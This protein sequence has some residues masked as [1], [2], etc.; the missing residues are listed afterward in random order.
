MNLFIPSKLI[1]IDPDK[2]SIVFI[3]NKVFN[4]SFDHIYGFGKIIIDYFKSLNKYNVV[5][6]GYEKANS[7]NSIENFYTFNT[8]YFLGLS[9]KFHRKVDDSDHTVY[10]QSFINK[11][12][13]EL[14]KD[15]DVEKVIILGDINFILPLTGYDTRTVEDH[16]FKKMQNEYFDYTGESQAI[17]NT[18]DDIN[19]KIV[20]KYDSVCNLLA[21]SMYLKNIFPNLIKFFHMNSKN[22]DKVYNFIIDPAFYTPFFNYNSIPTIN[23]Y[24]ADDKR[25]TRDFTKF[26]IAEL[27]HLV[28]E[29]SIKKENDLFDMFNAGEKNKD[30]FFMGS[31]LQSKGQRKNMW[32]LFLNNL[33]LNSD[34]NSLFVPLVMNGVRLKSS[35]GMNVRRLSKAKEKLPELVDKI[36]NHKLHKGDVT[37]SEITSTIQNYKY[38]LVLRCVSLNDS[39]NFRLI[40]YLS[41]DIIPFLDFLY[42]PEYLQIPKKFQDKLVVNDHIDIM[43]KINYYNINIDDRIKLLQDMKEYYSINSFK[44]K[45]N[46]YFNKEKYK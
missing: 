26:P 11:E 46:K 24:F 43:N 37:P 27:Q 16:S 33:E 22:F 20:K 12:Y 40:K 34:K 10:N 39:L 13:K 7:V 15:L 3:T 9:E 1:N 36:I 29:N 14:F 28:Y 23:Y 6:I 17:L 5:I 42:D 32:D 41:Q 21:F 30:F 19:K 45:L 8:T 25:G 18:I 38:G 35:T 2:K 44:Y 4:G 31:I